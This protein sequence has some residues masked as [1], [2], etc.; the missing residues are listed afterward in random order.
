MECRRWAGAAILAL[1]VAALAPL[2]HANYEIY[3]WL[4]IK[5]GRVFGGVHRILIN[6]D[7]HEH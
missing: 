2:K 3:S 5:F 4:A 6:D 7:L 1:N